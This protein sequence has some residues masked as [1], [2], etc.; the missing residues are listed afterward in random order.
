MEHALPEQRLDPVR[1]R[2]GHRGHHQARLRVRPQQR[3]YQG[4]CRQHFTY[5]HRVHPYGGVATGPNRLIAVIDKQPQTLRQPP[6][7]GRST[8]GAK[9]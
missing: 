8:P 7:I 3:F 5:R 9:Q 2:W 4:L 6:P 1:A